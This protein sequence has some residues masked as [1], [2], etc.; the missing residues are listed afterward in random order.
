MK[1]LIL[2]FGSSTLKFQVFEM[3]SKRLL[4]KGMADRIGLESGLIELKTDLDKESQEADFQDH[5]EALKHVL[6]LLEDPELGVLQTLSEIS[7]VGHRIVHGGEAYSEPVVIDEKVMK[8]I[9]DLS[10]LAPP[11]A[12]SL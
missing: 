1:V 4:A 9:R 12:P 3:P 10:F 5:G 7:L 11:L 6:G 8:T 2:N